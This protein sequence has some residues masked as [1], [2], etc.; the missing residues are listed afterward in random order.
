MPSGRRRHCSDKCRQAA[1]RRRQLPA[2]PELALPPKGARRAVTVYECD[3][4]G[5]RALGDQYCAECARFMRSIGR[6]GPCP[7]CDEPVAIADLMGGG[8]R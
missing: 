3:G 4:C 8:G 2:P 6:G 5:A 1:W 7:A